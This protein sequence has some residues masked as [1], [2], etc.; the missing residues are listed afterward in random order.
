VVVELSRMKIGTFNLNKVQILTIVKGSLVY[1][2][3]FGL[4]ALVISIIIF[5]NPLIS[6]FSK[7]SSNGSVGIAFSAFFGAFF[8]FMFGQVGTMIGRIN[9]RKLKHYNSLVLLE[10]QLNNFLNIISNNLITFSDLR[11]ALGQGKIYFMN[12]SKFVI[13]ESHYLNLLDIDLTNQLYN[14][15]DSAKRYNMDGDNLTISYNEIRNAYLDKKI[16]LPAYRV[17]LELTARRALM[18][19]THEK[20]Y[21]GKV[22]DLLA[23]VRVQLKVDR[24][25]LSMILSPLTRSWGGV[26][27]PLD[28]AKERVKLVGETEESATESGIEIEKVNEQL[29]EMG[30]NPIA[31][32]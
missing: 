30:V 31:Q 3:Y 24:P 16:E 10:S 28:V 2:V 17:N 25:T 12:L 11:R 19:E 21:T 23:R 15:L 7:L 1:A 13:D 4:T 8:A 27:S 22:L 14:V 9:E 5:F 6:F 18:I 32:V 20:A 26:I 29:K